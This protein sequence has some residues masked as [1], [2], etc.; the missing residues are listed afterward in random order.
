VKLT[1]TTTPGPR[2]Q[3]IAAGVALM[4]ALLAGLACTGCTATPAT[5]QPAT[6]QPATVLLASAQ[7]APPA[8]RA[9]VQSCIRFGISAIDRRVVVRTVPPACRGLSRAQVNF[10]VASAVHQVAAR[11]PGKANVRRRAAHFA[12]YL[13]HLVTAVHAGRPAPLRPALAS[14]QTSTG[15]LGLLALCSWLLTVGLGSYMMSRW[16]SRRTLRRTSLVGAVADAAPSALLNFTHFG[17]AVGGLLTW[18]AY[19]VTDT[20]LVGWIAC[21]ALLPATGFGMSL[22]F[23]G[24]G[25]RPAL[26]VAAHI[27]LAAA[28]LLLTL[29]T[30]VNSTAGAG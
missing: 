10:A 6:A 5:A 24:S 18:I 29:L 21:A 12:R 22:V 14:R 4:G 3:R 15:P 1:L 17:L 27:T 7:R 13:A 20:T 25:R 8:H 9:S 26:V 16:M 11:V 30:V 19:L 28:T 23:L 2:G